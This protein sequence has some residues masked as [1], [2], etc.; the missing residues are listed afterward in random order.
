V[1]TVVPTNSYYLPRCRGS[2]GRLDHPN[3]A[4]AGA[5]AFA[6]HPNTDDPKPSTNVTP[7]LRL[8]D[9]DARL[10][11]WAGRSAALFML[12]GLDAAWIDATPGAAGGANGAP[13]RCFAEE[14]ANDPTLASHSPVRAIARRRAGLASAKPITLIVPS[15]RGHVDFAGRRVRDAAAEKLKQS[16]TSRTSPARAASSAAARHP[17]GAGRYTLLVGVD[18]PISIARFV[19]H[20]GA[21]PTSLRD[22][23]RRLDMLNAAP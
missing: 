22:P 9:D 5:R 1:F 13:I 20:R 3:P 23:T 16:V 11:F 10:R 6:W 15:R 2:A 18:S 4:H 17:G 19:T 7:T 21:L 8:A 12:N 14:R